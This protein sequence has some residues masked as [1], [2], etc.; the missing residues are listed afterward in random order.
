MELSAVLISHEHSDHT[1]GAGIL[2]RKLDIP[3]YANE[4]TWLSMESDL[5]KI[6]PENKM[7]FD[8]NSEFEIGSIKIRA[9]AIPHDAANP[10]GFNL[11]S[12][13]RKFTV[14]TDIGHITK[15]LL[16]CFEMSDMILLES[17][18]DVDMLKIGRYPW[19]LK[20]RILS[21]KGHLSNEMAGKVI[22]YMACRGTRKFLLGHLSQEN[23]F[24]ELAY[25]TV[26]NVLCGNPEI[27]STEI[28]LDIA[29]RDSVG[30]VIE[31]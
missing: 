20:K 13:D 18:H 15:K 28:M 10:V 17:N 21:E 24:P 7:Y 9:F 22:E 11:F 25:Q 23:N 27:R 5:G 6:N 12:N 30:R 29:H 16:G 1:K 26:Y 19:P 4:E 2:S 3:L 31:V 14:A 8:M